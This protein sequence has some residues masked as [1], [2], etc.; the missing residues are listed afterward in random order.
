[1]RLSGIFLAHTISGLLRTREIYFQKQFLS[2]YTPP[3]VKSIKR[4][5]PTSILG[6]K[7]TKE[8]EELV[9]AA[10]S[11]FLTKLKFSFAAVNVFSMYFGIIIDLCFITGYMSYI[12]HSRYVIQSRFEEHLI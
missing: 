1:M 12:I 2:Y 6:F 5:T 8:E 3:S 9:G 11:G 4:G 10:F 7:E